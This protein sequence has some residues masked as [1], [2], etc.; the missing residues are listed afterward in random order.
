MFNRRQS[1]R[2]A[3]KGKKFN[4]WS[5]LLKILICVIV[6]VLIFFAVTSVMSYLA[7]QPGHNDPPV[8][9][10]GLFIFD[11]D[12]SKNGD[13]KPDVSIYL[14]AGKD[15]NKEL[16]AV[17]LVYVDS[18]LKE[19]NV[20][21]IPRM[22]YFLYDNID[23]MRLLEI[24]KNGG[25]GG[26]KKVISNSFGIPIDGT[27][28]I[29]MNAVKKL[30]DVVSGVKIDVPFN[31]NYKDDLQ[32]FEINLP[33]GERVLNAD[34]SEQ[35]IRFVSGYQNLETG[36]NEA[37]LNFIDK[38]LATSY[39]MKNLIIIPVILPAIAGDIETDMGIDQMATAVKSILDL[40]NLNFKTF[41]LQGEYSTLLSKSYF[42]IDKESAKETVYE[43]FNPYFSN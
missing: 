32:N 34:E 6:G 40:N 4:F 29:D 18:L 1:Y 17:F 19:V 16:D 2:S 15:Q 41:N 35:Y 22:F 25:I 30:V 33:K 12:L 24:Y 21:S 27:V 38:Y 26:L 13:R 37:Y 10:N 36:R 8:L 28:I 5:F 3:Y 20:L 39:S 43:N 42:V 23:N 14:V 31:F 9:E 11:S 7:N